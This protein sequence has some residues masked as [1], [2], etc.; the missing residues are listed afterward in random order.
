M[1]TLSGFAGSPTSMFTPSPGVYGRLVCTSCPHAA[2]TRSRPRPGASSY[3]LAVPGPR[4]R[5]GTHAGLLDLLDAGSKTRW[6]TPASEGHFAMQPIDTFAV[7]AGITE[8]NAAASQPAH[9]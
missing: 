1:T 7:R 6:P 2:D 3:H 8:V 4:R 5:C 9:T